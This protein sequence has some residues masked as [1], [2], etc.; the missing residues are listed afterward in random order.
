MS[1]ENLANEN[2]KFLF[3]VHNFDVPDEDELEEDVYVPPT[4]SEEELAAAKARA[5]ED[6]KKAGLEE[7]A[8]S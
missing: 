3:N 2:K 1:N 5:Y 7:S 8:A 6:G 4:F